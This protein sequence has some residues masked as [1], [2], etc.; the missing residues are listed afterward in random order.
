MKNIFDKRGN[1]VLVTSVTIGSVAAGT[2]AYLFLT[3]GGTNLRRRISDRFRNLFSKQEAQVIEVPGY[4]KKK[5]RAPKTDREEL[6]H[7]EP[8]QEHPDITS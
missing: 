2:L 4:L 1:G 8:I 3:E 6:L 7:R 5:S